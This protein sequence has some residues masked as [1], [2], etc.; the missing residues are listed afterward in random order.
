M[1]PVYAPI[2]NDREH[3]IA[4]MKWLNE[5][6]SQS[7]HWDEEYQELQFRHETDAVAFILKFGI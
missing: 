1:T 2:K 5:L 4:V 6:P 7:Y 3:E